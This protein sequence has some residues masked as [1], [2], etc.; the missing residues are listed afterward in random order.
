VVAISGG[1][2]GGGAGGN[3]ADLAIANNLSEI[4]AEGAAAQAAAR[5]N[6][7]NVPSEVTAPAN[8]A[9]LTMFPGGVVP[10]SGTYFATTQAGTWTIK[11]GWA[12][13]LFTPSQNA[14]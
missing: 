14:V 6:L 13:W 1:D 9:D 8:A 10:V 7:G 12:N 11:H 5:V 2:G 4:A 3:A